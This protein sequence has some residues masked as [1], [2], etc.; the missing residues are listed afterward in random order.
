MLNR[1]IVLKASAGE[2]VYRAEGA[3]IIED[4]VVGVSCTQVIE[5]GTPRQITIYS[6]ESNRNKEF[7]ESDFYLNPNDILESLKKNLETL[8]KESG[9]SSEAPKK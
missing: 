5:N 1:T 6:L 2:K 4:K 7:L 9:K 3:S 8:Q